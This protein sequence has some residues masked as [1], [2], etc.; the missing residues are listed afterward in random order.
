MEGMDEVKKL[1]EDI[2]KNPETKGDYRNR[3]DFIQSIAL[4][5]MQ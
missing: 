1:Y 5:S 2:A 4:D 3:E